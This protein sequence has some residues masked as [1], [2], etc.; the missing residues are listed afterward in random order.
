MAG[1]LPP[2]HEEIVSLLPSLRAFARSLTR[3]EVKAEDLVQETLTKA[4]A[5]IE[6]FSPGTN[7]R[8][9]LCTIQR[10]TFYTEHHKRSRE[11][12]A[13]ADELPS[14]NT[15]AP[16]EWSLRLR[17]VDEALQQLP[18][19]QREALMLVGGAGM[20]YE[21]A[22]AV[23]DCALGTIKSRVSRGRTGLRQLLEAADEEDFLSAPEERLVPGVASG[24]LPG[25]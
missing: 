9:W 20:T 14:L 18:V 17:A 5:N 15:K 13:A 6:K 7:L 21:E 23:C 25:D 4:V 19:D 1:R 12:V 3:D 10:N 8:A 24:P 2:I 16:Q 11:P 22:A